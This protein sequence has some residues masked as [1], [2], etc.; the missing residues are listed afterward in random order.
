MNSRKFW[1]VIC[2]E[3]IPH[4]EVPCLDPLMLHFI[5]FVTLKYIA[6]MRTKTNQSIYW[7][8]VY[9]MVKTPIIAHLTLT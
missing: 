6:S 4:M 8:P 5:D 7:Q 1:S 3:G 2:G 9:Q